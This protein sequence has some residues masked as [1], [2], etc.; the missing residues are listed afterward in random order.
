MEFLQDTVTFDPT[1]IKAR[2]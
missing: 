2:L 1:I